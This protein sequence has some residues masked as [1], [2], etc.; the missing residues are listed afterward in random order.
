MIVEE[1]PVDLRVSRS[2][3]VDSDDSAS[4]P[5]VSE[6]ITEGSAVSSV[7]SSSLSVTTY[8]H[9]IILSNRGCGGREG[10]TLPMMMITL[11]N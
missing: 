6:V 11:P 9:L 8:H 5:S 2:P 3:S 4:L 1:V 10:A 7:S